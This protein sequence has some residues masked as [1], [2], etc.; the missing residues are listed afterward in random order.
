M[1]PNYPDVPSELKLELAIKAQFTGA[2]DKT[3]VPLAQRWYTIEQS[4]SQPS[5]IIPF[6]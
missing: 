2:K 5:T 3:N 4:Y 1:W 6:S